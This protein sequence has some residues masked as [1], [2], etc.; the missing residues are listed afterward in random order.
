MTKCIGPL[1][2]IPMPLLVLARTRHHTMDSQSASYVLEVADFKIG[3]EDVED[4]H[5]AG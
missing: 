5:P 1:Q 3:A 4:S 2:D